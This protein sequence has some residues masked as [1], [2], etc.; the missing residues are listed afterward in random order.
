MD[1]CGYKYV[2]E[3]SALGAM[4]LFANP[5]QKSIFVLISMQKTNGRSQFRF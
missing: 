1:F 4:K 3:G 5:Q 2:S